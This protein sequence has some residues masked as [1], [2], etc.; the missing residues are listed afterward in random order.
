ME[1]WEARQQFRFPVDAISCSV[2]SWGQL[3]ERDVFRRLY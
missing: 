3:N 1:T 2:Y